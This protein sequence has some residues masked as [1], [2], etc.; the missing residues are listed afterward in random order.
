MVLPLYG[1]SL[2]LPQMNENGDIYS[3]HSCHKEEDS[4]GISQCFP[5]LRPFPVIIRG[6]SLIIPH[7]VS[8]DF[9]L[10]W[11][12]PPGVGIIVGHKIRKNKCKHE[13]EGAKEEEE[14]LPCSY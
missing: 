11:S 8:C 2:A 13:A 9:S 3:S 14:Y 7:S 5:K 1:Y 12:E 4:L 10:A 6:N